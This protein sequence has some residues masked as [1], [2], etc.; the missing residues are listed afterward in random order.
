MK[1]SDLGAAFVGEYGKD[2]GFMR[3][4]NINGAQGLLFHCPKPGCSHSIVIWFGNPNS[5]PVVPQSASPLT[6]WAVSGTCLDDLTLSP[7]I[8]IPDDWHGWI[9]N[10]QV[11]TA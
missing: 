7:S 8:S 11:L 6:R 1:L 5:A 10:G 4:P 3:L 9:T 2:D